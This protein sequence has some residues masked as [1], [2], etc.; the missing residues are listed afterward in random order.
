MARLYILRHGK[1][2][3]VSSTGLDFDR[4]LVHRGERN[5]SQ[6][7]KMIN[8]HFPKPGLIIFSPANRTRQTT[9]LVQAE[10]PNVESIEDQRIYNADPETLF[11][12]ITDHGFD[13]ETVMLVGH[14]PGLILLI[15]ML[16]AEDGNRA[17]HNIMDYPSA[18]FAELVFEPKK[19]GQ[20]T[21]DSG[22]LLKLLRPREMTTLKP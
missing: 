11:D 10:I 15:H 2:E 1:T 4:D 16:M 5:S 17:G 14:N 8:D 18:A 20:I 19:F 9:N 7:G 22:V 13:H 12:V 6:I 3:L 21:R